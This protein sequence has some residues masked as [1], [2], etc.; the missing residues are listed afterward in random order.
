MVGIDY[1]CSACGR[2]HHGTDGGE[3]SP[4]PALSFR[5]P[6][7]Y[8]ALSRHQ[9]RHHAAATDDLCWIAAG[10]EVRCFVRGCL[11]VPIVGEDI[12][13][14]YGLW[15][16]VSEEV[17]L[18]YQLHF[19]DAEG[20]ALYVGAAAN[21]IPGYEQAEAVP[22]QIACLPFP[23]RPRLRPDSLYRHPLVRD[24]HRG[25]SRAEAELRIRAFLLGRGGAV[26]P[27]LDG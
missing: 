15:V 4:W 11:S 1:R 17:F 13:L 10:P 24:V 12:T 26:P 19:E 23:H 5:R 22:L 2:E 7:R 3:A 14:E 16:E 25:I 27:G 6:D 18:D 9:R 20:G 8:V 21:A